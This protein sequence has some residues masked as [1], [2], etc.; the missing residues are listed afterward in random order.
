MKRMLGGL[1][2]ALALIWG[3][4]AKAARAD[5]C[6]CVEYNHG[7]AG[8][9]TLCFSEPSW[10]NHFVQCGYVESLNFDQTP[11]TD[12]CRLCQD[13]VGTYKYYPWYGYTEFTISG[14][15]NDGGY[16]Q[17]VGCIIGNEVIG[18]AFY[19]NHC[20]F[21]TGKYIMTSCDDVPV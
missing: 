3:T 18:T 15:T 8:W 1:V 4:E 9:N 14:W 6:V 21:G 20:I 19:Y 13:P 16:V 12:N 10:G 5:T 17:I 7:K 2:F 11:T